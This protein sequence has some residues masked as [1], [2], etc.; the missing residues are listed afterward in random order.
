MRCYRCGAEL[1]EHSFCTNCGTDVALYKK[2]IRT[3]NT[4]Y[5]E[6][7]EKAKVRDLS[8]AVISLRQSLKFNKN[9]IKARNLLGLV[10][11]EMGEVVAALSEWVI[12][13]NLR[14]KKNVAADYIER[15]QSNATLTGNLNQSIKKYNQAYQYCL[16]PDGKDLA[17]VQ[18]K[19][20]IS[21][22][23]KLVR[24]YQMLGLVYVCTNRPE[25]AL[26]YLNKAREIDVN[27]TMTLRYIKEA[28]NMIAAANQGKKTS[29]KDK[30]TG[31]NNN[32]PQV[33]KYVDDNEYVIQP[34]R[35]TERRGS[36]TILNIIIGIAV[37][38]LI[39]FFL[40]LPARIQHAQAAAQEEIKGFGT[41]LDAKN[42]AINELEKKNSEQ[43]DKIRALTENL[44]AY[45]GTEGTLASMENLLK[46]AAIY[47]NN[48]ES[49]LEVADYITSIDETS[50]TDDTS[51]NYKNLYYALKAAIGVPVCDSYYMEG[52]K[53]YSGKQYDDAIAYFEAAVFFD[54]T[55]ADAI[56]ML[57]NCYRLTE[58]ESQ[59]KD[60]YNKVV[61]LFPNTWYSSNA[62]KYLRE[63]SD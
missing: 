21:L 37:G 62:E 32:G 50:W 19:R 44:N 39:A 17:V 56:Y 3:S 12:S 43:E 7:L 10:Y 4:L 27:S 45:A 5:N 60:A 58:K 47:L 26:T 40:V 9:N 1:S 36:G 49:Y 25:A 11:Y 35:T 54:S 6:G 59:A 28:E 57:A 29:L 23:P 15:V 2:I 61:E 38:F 22:N 34:I 16:Q 55:D 53:A 18:L 20:V 46:A 24:A 30:I 13:T 8:G 33:K 63:Y 41:E 31:D 14:N 48:P 52:E 51:E 42:L